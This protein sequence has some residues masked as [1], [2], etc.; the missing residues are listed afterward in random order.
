MRRADLAQ[1]V[2]LRTLLAVVAVAMAASMAAG[3][4]IASTV[5]ERGATGPAGPPGPEGEEGLPGDTGLTGARG[6]RGPAGPPGAEGP[7]GPAGSS[8]DE[9]VWA[10]IESDTSRLADAA[11]VSDLCSDLEFAPAL[12]DELLTCP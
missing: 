4:G 5:I 9:D 11:G 12:E 6:A 7:P 10:V 8:E 2:T 1:P 3:I